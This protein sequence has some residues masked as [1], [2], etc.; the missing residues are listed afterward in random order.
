MYSQST[1]EV[2]VILLE[3]SNESDPSDPIRTAL[4]SENLDSKLTVDDVDTHSAAVTFA[5]GFFAID[6]PEEAGEEVSS[7]RLTVDNVDR[8]IVTAIRNATEPPEVRMWVV[9]RSS[10]DV[11]E[12]G[13]YYFVLESA[14]YDAQS[15]SGELSFE[16]ITS[17][18]YPKHEFTPYLVPGLF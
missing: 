18:R 10:P 6:L 7:V 2:F 8:T 3:I 9:L 4:D 13:P 16:D 15:V 11:V 17:R 12:A 14:D 5:G 1:E